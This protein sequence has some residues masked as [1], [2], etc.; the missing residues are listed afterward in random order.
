MIRNKIWDIPEK[1]KV[2]NGIEFDH[3]ENEYIIWKGL[4]MNI[5]SDAILTLNRYDDEI[6]HVRFGFLVMT[7]YTHAAPSITVYDSE[8]RR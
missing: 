3:E 4:N 7:L 1:V 5:P 8:N 2:A 6:V